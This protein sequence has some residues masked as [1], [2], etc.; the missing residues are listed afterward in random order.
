MKL[1]ELKNIFGQ[2]NSVGVRYIVVGGLAVVAQGYPRMTH[3]LDIVIK[4]ESD[5]MTGLWGVLTA[6]G[7]VPSV[8]VTLAEFIDENNR[9]A[10]QTDKNMQVLHFQ[11]PEWPFAGVD[12]F[13]QEPFDFD[14]EYQACPNEEIAP[15]LSIRYARIETLIA[16][17]S[18]TGRAK[19]ADDIEN[20]KLLLG[21]QK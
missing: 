18:N 4:L 1:V 5:D 15:G 6:I 2:L 14:T 21:S 17:K 7:Y 13:I 19:D 3:D 8:P 20:L 9:R 16:M 11:H 10:W 12:V